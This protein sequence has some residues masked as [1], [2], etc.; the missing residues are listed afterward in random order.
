[1]VGDQD[2][3]VWRDVEEHFKKYAYAGW[4]MKFV[5]MDGWEEVKGGEEQEQDE[6]IKS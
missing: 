5:R 1:L 6:G 4:R 2:S 3:S